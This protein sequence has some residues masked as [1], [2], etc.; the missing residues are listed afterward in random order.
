MKDLWEKILKTEGDPRTPPSST[1]PSQAERVGQLPVGDDPSAEEHQSKITPGPI[2]PE[3]KKS[4]G[5]RFLKLA[6]FLIVLI[7]ALISI[8][9]APILTSLGS[10]LVV[11]H[12]LSK[13][14]AILCLSG[15][16]VERGLAS[17]ELYKKGLAPKIII[18]R[19]TQ[20]DGYARLKSM[21]IDYPEARDLLLKV[22]VG[23]GVPTSAIISDD[24]TATSTFVE[25]E[26]VKMIIEKQKYRTIIIVTSP[27][28]TKRA[29]LTFR[30]VL[31]ENKVRVIMHG[32]PY[33]GFSPEEWWK[34]RRYLKNVII[35]YQKLV[36]YTLKHL[37]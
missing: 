29:W 7:Y 21:G 34:N 12:P 3:S 10:F 30:E 25:A 33:S 22:L 37:L 26:L 28:H 24:K 36:Y 19:E 6:V 13:A 23:L 8:Y 9:H 5:G 11:E 16:P 4:P 14:D 2:E 15:A 35:E 17:A 18:T 1:K 27:Y 20:P 31:K 32:S